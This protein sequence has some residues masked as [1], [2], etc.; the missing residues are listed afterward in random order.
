MKQSASCRALTCKRP[1]SRTRT[2]Q[3][4]RCS[5]S[6]VPPSSTRRGSLSRP[7]DKRYRGYVRWERMGARPTLLPWHGFPSRHTSGMLHQGHTHTAPKEVWRSSRNRSAVYFPA[8]QRF[9]RSSLRRFPVPC[10]P[11]PPRLPMTD[12]SP[13][14]LARARS[15]P[16][17]RKASTRVPLSSMI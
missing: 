1:S 6:A 5:S 16:T 4:D 2:E 7:L 10:P 17:A 12:A 8:S 11:S 3:S 9:H 15:S 14:R 13:G